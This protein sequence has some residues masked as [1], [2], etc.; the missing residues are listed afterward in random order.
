MLMNC[1]I[2]LF[3]KLKQ[4]SSDAVLNKPNIYQEL[5]LLEQPILHPADFMEEL[6]TAIIFHTKNNGMACSSTDIKLYN[7][8][9]FDTGEFIGSFYA[10]SYNGLYYGNIVGNKEIIACHPKAF[11][12]E[13]TNELFVPCRIIFDNIYALICDYHAESGTLKPLRFIET[14]KQKKDRET[15][16]DFKNGENIE[17]ALQYCANIFQ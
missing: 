14:D 16:H 1:F 12:F 15:I 5:G 3:A 13:E 2:K 6:L 9:D 10:L 7:M 8:F 11:R 17:V 4:K